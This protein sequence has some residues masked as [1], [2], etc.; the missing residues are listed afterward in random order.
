MQSI[1]DQFVI[2]T[3]VR[4]KDTLVDVSQVTFIASLG[5]GMLVNAAKGLQRQGA[6][7]VLLGPSTLVRHALEAAGINQVI[8][9][10]NEESA[11]LELLR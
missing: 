4:R 3:T 11:A 7:M 6:K 1:Q 10:A 5:M 9:I 2:Q 8:P